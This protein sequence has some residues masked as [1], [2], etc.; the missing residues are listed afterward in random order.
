M[1]TFDPRL[2]TRTLTLGVLG[3]LRVVGAH[4]PDL[5]L[6]RNQ[7]GEGWDLGGSYRLPQAG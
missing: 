4:A 5:Y 1:A 7:I 2:V 6:A 3:E